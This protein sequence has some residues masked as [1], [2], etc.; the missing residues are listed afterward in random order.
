MFLC[1]FIWFVWGHMYRGACLQT[2][3]GTLEI[4]SF[5]R[6]RIPE[7]S[8]LESKHFWLLGRLTD[9]SVTFVYMLRIFDCS[10]LCSF[11][12]LIPLWALGGLWLTKNTFMSI[13][14]SLNTIPRFA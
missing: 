1:L 3:E 11:R 12:L 14:V 5:Y 10:A 9:L 2:L 8:R 6:V 4:S 13:F 7:V